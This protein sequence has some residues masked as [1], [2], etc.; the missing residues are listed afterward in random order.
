M[1]GEYNFKALAALFKTSIWILLIGAFISHN[2]SAENSYS[3]PIPEIQNLIQNGSYILTRGN[4][5]IYSYDEDNKLVPASIWKIATSLAALKTLGDDFRFKTEFYL[6]IDNNLYIKGFGDPFLVSE[7]IDSIFNKL[8]EKGLVEI[9][10]IYLDSSAFNIT[11]APNGVSK[12]LNPYDVTNS[13]LAVNFNTIN[14]KVSS[15][16]KVSSAEKQTPT[17]PI[18]RDLGKDF[19]K[20]TH[21]IN[22]SRSPENVLRHSGELFRNI[23]LVNGISGKGTIQNK[24]TPQDLK[25]FYVHHSSKSLTEV[26]EAMMLYSNNFIANQIYLTMGAQEYEYPATWEKSKIAL[27]K[28]I[29]DNF[30]G[31]SDSIEFD[32]GSG[33]SRNNRITAHVMIEILN[34]FKPYAALLPFEDNMFI[35]SGTLK[36]V[37][38]YAGYFMRDGGYDSFVII[39]NQQ[40]N[41]RDKVLHSLKKIYNTASD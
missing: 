4:R 37:Y 14:F 11:S 7:E 8:K 28:Y 20:G 17:L 32:E 13:A 6:D 35:K 3:K 19:R 5:I 21:R 15:N 16:G 25:P 27:K 38:S 18:M 33:I 40:R 1:T 23:Q 29:N 24:K 34:S 30:P 22:I 9:N 10:N 31:Y 12:S 41:Y 36:G 2:I 26:I 39:L